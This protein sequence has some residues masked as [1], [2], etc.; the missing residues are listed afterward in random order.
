M[1]ARISRSLLAFLAVLFF[2][3][4]ALAQLPPPA[5]EPGDEPKPKLPP[6]PRTTPPPATHT[7]RTTAASSSK[8]AVNPEMPVERVKGGE[9][10]FAWR[11]GGLA[12]L[13]ATGNG[14][15]VGNIIL[16]E[17]ALKYVPNENWRVIGFFGTGLRL[18]SPEGG[19]SGTDWGLSLGGGFEYHFRIWRRISPYFGVQLALGLRDP[20]GDIGGDSNLSF[21][22][23]LGPQIG[24]EYFIFDHVSLQ[25][26]YL[27]FL[28]F[29]LNT[30]AAASVR[31]TRFEF[32]TGAGGA[33]TLTIYF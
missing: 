17:I 28:Q 27:F 9:W 13:A 12:S 26:T 18:D 33:L 3:N 24:I 4:A 6:P 31:G 8:P 22:L 15:G 19:T 5:P 21:S 14:S 2:A 11:F 25:A 1:S 23:S 7:P 29:E 10:G 20:A 16:T 32:G 30:Y